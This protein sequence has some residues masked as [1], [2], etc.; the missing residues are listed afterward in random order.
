MSDHVID[1][2][3]KTAIAAT[4]AKAQAPRRRDG[5]RS[6]RGKRAASAHSVAPPSMIATS[7]HA[8]R[9]SCEPPRLAKAVATTATRIATVSGSAGCGAAD[10]IRRTPR[11]SAPRSA[12]YVLRRARTADTAPDRGYAGDDGRR[13]Q[14][15]E[16]DAHRHGQVIAPN[17]RG[18]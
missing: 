1:S 5:V 18:G 7:V 4:P 2:A 8:V 16:D 12:T 15:S 17:A 14:Q 13:G 11:R 10:D 9:S 3:V 6:G